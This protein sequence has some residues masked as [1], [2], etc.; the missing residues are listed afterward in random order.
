MTTRTTI[1]SARKIITMHPGQPT[2]T[3]VAVK[4]GRILAVGELDDLVCRIKR[5]PFTPYEVDT[6]LQDKIL[7]P[8][9]V[10]AHTHVE[11]QA[12]QY[13]GHF[14]SQIEWPRPEGGFFPTYPTKEDV[15]DRLR[16]LDK[17]LPP[18]EV[19]FGTAYDENKTGSGLRV[20][21]L[22]AI[23]TK[24]PIIVS[25][26]VFHRFWVNSH[27]L[28][29]AGIEPG[30]V[31]PGVETDDD[32][33]PNGTLLESR[34]LS[35]VLL[36]VPDLVDITEEKIR[37]ILPLF[38]AGGTTTLYDAG[39]G[40]FDMDRCFGQYQGI[41]S[42][43]DV[44]TRVLAGPFALNAI[45][46]AGSIDAFIEKVRTFSQKTFDEFRFGPIKLYADGSIISHTADVG[47]PGYW[48][49]APQGHWQ[50]EP[51]PLA[52]MLIRL[53]EEGFSTVTH[54]NGRPAIQAVLDAVAEAQHRCYRPDMRHRVDHCY[55]MTDAQ[56][57]Q[58]KTLGVTVQFFTTQIYYYGDSHLEVQGPDRAH[59]M[60]PTGS[61]KRIGTVW[62]FHNDPP[63]TPQ[64]P[65]V[66]AWATVNRITQDSGTVLGPEQKVSVEDALQALT[67]GHAYQLHLEHEI[68]SIEFG[69]KADFCVLEADATQIDPMDLKDVPIWGTVFGGRLNPA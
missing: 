2:A 24:R 40:A 41:F 32:G 22:D 23:S 67:I 8:G 50:C 3:A 31:P 43:P 54:T 49:G 56:L 52:E 25:N 59:Q 15:L 20:E 33:A 55:N 9:L 27:L 38:A 1:Y 28:N 48:D 10:D 6:T 19:L 44:K 51:E 14:V 62:G 21:E 58:A 61:A 60:T 16:E 46:R 39:F 36:F 68:G 26:S 34:G 47:W 7:M 30:N 65:L 53:H 64:L 69:K 35:S 4:D 29:K 66:G 18:G 45:R 12:M 13:A 11:V 42:D 17:T 57:Q 37:Y 63:G 5:S